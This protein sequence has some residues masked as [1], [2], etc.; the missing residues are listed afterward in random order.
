LQRSLSP[1]KK[2]QMVSGLR[3]PPLASSWGAFS[4]ACLG[5]RGLALGGV[6]QSMRVKRALP[7]NALAQ[8]LA[9]RSEARQGNLA[10]ARAGGL[11]ARFAATSAEVFSLK[12]AHSTEAHRT[13]AFDRGAGESN[14]FQERLPPSSLVPVLSEPLLGFHARF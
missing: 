3:S 2:H 1:S 4:L 8:A 13:P 7:F 12:Q 14:A 6:R 10:R 11:V 5:T 9:S